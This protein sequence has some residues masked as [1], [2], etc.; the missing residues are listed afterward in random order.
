MVYENGSWFFCL[1]ETFMF[2]TSWSLSLLTFRVEA[3]FIYRGDIITIIYI[4]V[5][6]TWF[7]RILKRMQK[8]SL[9]LY[10]VHFYSLDF[11]L[12]MYNVMELNSVNRCPLHPIRL[13]ETFVTK[14]IVYTFNFF[15]NRFHAR[16]WCLL[17]Y[18]RHLEKI[19][20]VFCNLIFI[21]LVKTKKIV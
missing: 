15:V 19:E 4:Q 20:S 21:I 6:K 1:N 18:G 7:D 14:N 11:F 17:Y 16:S 8:L 12:L 13:Q 9:F 5:N 3:V 10:L 2:V